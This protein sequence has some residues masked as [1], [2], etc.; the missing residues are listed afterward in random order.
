[1]SGDRT[2]GKMQERSTEAMPWAEG[3]NR[4]G[5]ATHSGQG[6]EVMGGLPTFSF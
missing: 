6:E 3:C 1:M 5:G 2:G 4:G